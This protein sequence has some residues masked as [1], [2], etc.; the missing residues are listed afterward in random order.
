MYLFCEQSLAY[1]QSL[2]PWPGGSTLHTVTY[3]PARASQAT[4][5]PA[6]ATKEHADRPGFS[7]SFAR[8]A[9]GMHRT[10]TLDY[11]L[12]LEAETW[13]EM[14]DGKAIHLKLG[15]MII[16]NGT[17]H[18]WRNKGQENAT[19]LFVILGANTHLRRSG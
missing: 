18:A 14:D 13:R 4:F 8:K 19:M 15:D 6:A 16:Q 3:P 12:V 9:P 1:A 10:N 7:D 2:I 5:D 11:A 17:R